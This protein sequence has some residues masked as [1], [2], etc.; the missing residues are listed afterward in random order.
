MAYLPPTLATPHPLDAVRA[1]A[2]RA[3]VAEN[4]RAAANVSPPVVVDAGHA[5]SDAA[6]ATT[7]ADAAAWPGAPGPEAAAGV[8]FCVRPRGPMPGPIVT[9]TVATN[10]IP[11]PTLK[12]T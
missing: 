7:G 4:A 10:A 12:R 11:R 6:G 2:S 3:S 9:M 8:A 1:K 5:P